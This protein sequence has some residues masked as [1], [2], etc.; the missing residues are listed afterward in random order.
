MAGVLKPSSVPSFSA[1]CPPRERIGRRLVV[2]YAADDLALFEEAS[3]A[4]EASVVAPPVPIPQTTYSLKAPSIDNYPT[5]N[6]APKLVTEEAT[7]SGSVPGLDDLTAA[8]SQAN[9]AV[10]KA[11]SEAT[12]A[13]LDAF[14]DLSSTVGGA[15]DQITGAASLFSDQLFGTVTSVTQSLGEQLGSGAKV[16][17]GAAGGALGVANEA[18]GGVTSAVTEATSLAAATTA[19]LEGAATS[20]L[21]TVTEATGSALSGVVGSL[22]PEVRDG[23]GVAAS[24]LAGATSSLAQL[25]NQHPNEAATVAGV[26]GAT[27]FV[28]WYG[29]SFAGFSGELDPATVKALL[30]DDSGKDAILID[31]REEEQRETDGLPEL[32]LGARYRAAALPLSAADAFMIKQTSDRQAL[33]LGVSAAL[34]AGL[35]QVQKSS[36]SS[37][38]IMDAKGQGNTAK[39][40]ARALRKEGVSQ[41]YVMRG[42]FEG[43]VNADL[44]VAEDGAEYSASPALFVK[45]EIELLASQAKLFAQQLQ[46]PENALPVLGVTAFASVVLINYHTTLQVIGLWGTAFSIYNGSALGL[47][48]KV[49]STA[50]GAISSKAEP[51]A[52]KVPAPIPPPPSPVKVAEPSALAAA[53]AAASVDEDMG[54]SSVAVAKQS[55]V[56]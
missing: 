33:R 9:E 35:K 31:I 55:A 45:D 42:G 13:A 41:A 49:L 38:V 16:V 18:L 44:P 37:V 21:T 27:V 40:L 28:N 6:S 11:A 20:A 53:I 2:A 12:A 1:S 43:W 3:E 19:E 26:A 8:G 56:E 7:Q 22:P 32:K 10:T 54:S 17:E 14:S 29:S 5:L 4:S 50:T 23:L 46:R 15:T 24:S 52:K 36:S 25:I 51:K 48:N 30:Q 34:I 39:E 47:L